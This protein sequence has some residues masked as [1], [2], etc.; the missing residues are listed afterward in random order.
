MVVYETDVQRQ[1]LEVS[2]GRS[3]LE[4]AF[5]R[6]RVIAGERQAPLCEVEI[7]LTSG[8][9]QDAVRLARTWCARHGLW[10][11][12]V[13][14]SAKAQRLAQQAGAAV[15]TAQPLQLEHGVNIHQALAAMVLNC[16]DQ[17]LGNASDVAGDAAGGNADR[18]Q[19]HQLRIGLRRLRTVLRE[20]GPTTPAIDTAWEPELARVFRALGEQRDQEY[21]TLQMQP[22][23]VAVGGPAFE[24]ILPEPAPDPAQAVRSASFQRTLVELLGF[25]HGQS[26]PT[27]ADGEPAVE[28]VRA[29]LEHL[30]RRIVKEGHGFLTLDE[31]HQH[32]LRKRLKRLRY[33]AE[34]ARPLFKG[35]EVD[36]Y[37]RQLKP[38]QDTLGIFNDRMMAFRFYCK[39]A[40]NEPRAWFGIGWLSGHR[41]GD[42][43]ACQRALRA[44]GK[45][46]VFW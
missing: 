26:A 33:L 38:L 31:A 44:L 3:T 9:P 43:K 7:E 4:L 16:M 11:S 6:G 17:V 36:K 8:K 5:D 42:A 20:L 18:E 12:T 22:Q 23:L 46:K 13:S 30:H 39:L 24:L 40:H 14:K 41:R 35:K 25:A 37:L 27:N 19:I 29:R 10:L 15:V 28:A 1:V 45:L 32:R 2:S 21:I 34:L